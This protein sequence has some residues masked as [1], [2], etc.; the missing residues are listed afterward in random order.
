M[1]SLFFI[2]NFYGICCLPHMC[3]ICMCVYVVVP[4]MPACEGQRLTLGIF[5]C[6]SCFLAGSL[7][8]PGAHQFC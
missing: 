7:T 4:T 8:E 1:P 2:V 6:H 3:V 5:L